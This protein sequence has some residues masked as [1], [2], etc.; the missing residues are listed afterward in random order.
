MR[1]SPT[2][3]HF[4]IDELSGP[5]RVLA[6]FGVWSCVPPQATDVFWLILWF[7]QPVTDCNGRRFRTIQPATV[8]VLV[9]GPG[10]QSAAD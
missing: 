1:V 4:V 8:C 3:R 2:I 5:G 10:M 7:A 9:R 6:D